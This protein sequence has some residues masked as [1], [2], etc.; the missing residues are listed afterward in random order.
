[1][2][3]EV[4]KMFKEAVAVTLNS[5]QMNFVAQELDPR[6]DI[7]KASGFGHIIAIPSHAGATCLVDF[8]GTE[9]RLVRFLECLFQHD[10]KF[11]YDS[12]C[13]VVF[14]NEIITTLLNHR[15]IYDA[16]CE[17][18]F[19]DHFFA[20][21]MNFLKGIE[22]IDLR[23]NE[24][25]KPGHL[26]NLAEGIGLRS[27]VLGA[28]DLSWQITVRANRIS[29]EVPTLIREIVHLL[30]VKQG[31]GSLSDDIFDCIME[32][33]I[34]ARNRIYRSVFEKRN[35]SLASDDPEGFSELFER[36]LDLHGDLNLSAYAEEEDVSFDMNFKSSENAIS[37]WT[38]THV[39][40][41]P[42]QKVKLYEK[43]LGTSETLNGD[44]EI[45]RTS[46]ILAGLTT[47]SDPMKVV[48]YPA[49]TKVGFYLR[50][51]QLREFLACAVSKG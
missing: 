44:S 8:L 25:Q 29:G 34:E 36:E 39:T 23:S 26:V 15:W 3:K 14:K 1:M 47:D 22:F 50:R 2:N 48:F 46:R 10:G 41:R 43:L 19:R 13:K 45:T 40:M 28:E 31:L 33:A 30:M 37:C 17:R 27:E 20:A 9:E 32:L 51:V 24:S 18:F 16:D 4:Q 11:L 5:D 7:R 6:F 42:R 49:R 35:P 12:V 38:I 21:T